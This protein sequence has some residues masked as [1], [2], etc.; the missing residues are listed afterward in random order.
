VI[1][2]LEALNGISEISYKAPVIR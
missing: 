2:F 1:W